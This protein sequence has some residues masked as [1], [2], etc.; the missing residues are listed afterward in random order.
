M[1]L[2]K[3][4]R[5]INQD[6]TDFYK[7]LTQRVDKYFEDHQ[8][9][10]HANAEMVI[11]SVV[12]LSLYFVPYA[13]IMSG[14][15]SLNG[16]WLMSALMGFGVAGIGMSIMHDANHGA[17][18]DNY[19]V[20]KMIGYT[21][22]IVGGDADNWKVQHNKMHHTYTNIHGF[23]LDI[24][25]TAGLRFSPDVKHQ[26]Y[27]RFQLV[28]IFILYALQTFF[29]VA[30][31]DFIQLY[32][33]KQK[34]ID[35]LDKAGRRKHLVI[36]LITKLIYVGYVVVLPL[37][38]LPITG[39]QWL[40]GFMTMHFTGG[41][42]LALVF[43]LAHVVEGISYPKPNEQGQISE[44]WAVHQMRTTADF[45]PHNRLLSYYVGGLNF[46]IEH[47]LFTRI[48]HV[49][50]PAIAPIVKQTAAEYGIPYLCNK[51]MM[52]AV[53]AH[54]R[55]MGKLGRDELLVAATHVG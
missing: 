9:S 12:M 29:W 27:Q 34:G 14:A 2:K 32:T 42:T 17:Y 52:Q 31:K 50:Y 7:V 48:C 24:K 54:F 1:I 33:F 8:I 13:F 18:S 28:Y 25:E 53:R 4:P 23:D 6:K 5:F 43:Q 22:N 37:V 35:G 51:S 19:V 15:L 36:L 45:S 11:K 46:Q 39:W 47:H 26:H 16:M 10:K 49:H 20:N 21:L 44:E 41:F 38:F 40:L 30:I 55:I 3:A